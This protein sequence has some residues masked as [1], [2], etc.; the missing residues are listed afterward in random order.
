M[1]E[2]IAELLVRYIEEDTYSFRKFT[3]LQVNSIGLEGETPL[4]MASLRGAAADVAILI[5]AGA[6]PNSVNDVGA[7]PLHRAV[8]AGN[9]Q[10][11]TQLLDAGAQLVKNNYGTTPH[12]LAIETGNK[13]IIARLAIW[14]APL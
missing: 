13:A 11:V 10:I 3:H 1:T 2:S 12:D 6:N 9:L 14:K 8:Y 5:E 4:H 7:T